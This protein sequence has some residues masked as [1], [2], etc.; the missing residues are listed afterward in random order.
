MNANL[1]DQATVRYKN[2]DYRG[3]LRGYTACLQDTS[4]PFSLGEVGLIYHRIGNCLVKLGNPQEAIQAYNQALSD[5]SYKAKGALQNNIGMAYASLKDYAKASEHFQAAID[6]DNYESVY[7]AY[8][9]LGNAQL[10]LG[11]S[12]EAGVAFR[13]AALDENNTDP[14]KAL[15]NLG[16]CFMALDRPQDAILSYESALQFD[17]NSD[18]RNRIN[19]SM[20]QAYVADGQMAEAIEAFKLATDDATYVLSDSAAVDYQKALNEVAKM[21]P[22]QLPKEAEDS[23]LISPAEGI[24]PEEAYSMNDTSGL[25]VPVSE[26]TTPVIGAAAQQTGQLQAMQTQA[27]AP[28]DSDDPFFYAGDVNM[29][30]E[31]YPGYLDAYDQTNNT[32]FESTDDEVEKLS[33]S[34]AKKNRRMRNFGLK[35]LIVIII[36]IA[37]LLGVGVVGYMMGYGYPTQQTT[38]EQLFANPENAADEVFA[39]GLS[40]ENIDAMLVTVVESP[41]V[42]FDAIEASAGSSTA[43][44]TATT[45]KGGKIMYKIAMVRD[46]VGWK[47][48][49]IELY[50]PSQNVA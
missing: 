4:V 30:A 48:S 9:G 43:Y 6:D 2:L 32:F 16:I 3:A 39:D 46:L 12:A 29:G 7:K 47:V 28:V 45:D 14:A 36:L 42:E 17:M 37:V 24:T 49:Q 40:K 50:F 33:K 41:T 35:I 10:K 38:I 44:V 13:E 20:G 31:N 22:Q 8:M 1:F 18:T 15:L 19:A 25:D 5:S 26:Y 27:I 21:Q 34:L 11:N 23:G